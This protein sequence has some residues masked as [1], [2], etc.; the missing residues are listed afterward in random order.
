MK[1]VLEH[2]GE[3]YE[4]EVIDNADGT[5]TLKMGDREL[6]ADFLRSENPALCSLILGGRSY[7]LL[8]VENEDI[9]SV[10]THGLGVD[11]KVE[12]EREHNARMISGDAGG[13]GPVVIKAAMPGIVVSVGVAVGDAVEKGQSVAVL[14]AMKMENEVR[15]P[16][17]GIVKAI[18]V[19]AGETVDA[20]A[21]LLEVGPAEES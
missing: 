9:T 16:G 6:S 12:S 18:S 19:A 2:A 11:L 14:E 1:Y 20:G 4:I 21:V 17:A 7:E 3:Q 8:V 5:H 13:G 15:S 10:T